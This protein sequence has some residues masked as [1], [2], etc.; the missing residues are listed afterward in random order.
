M[1]SAEVLTIEPVAPYSVRGSAKPREGGF[2]EMLDRAAQRITESIEEKDKSDEPSEIAGTG[3]KVAAFDEAETEPAAPPVGGEKSETGEPESGE[4]SDPKEEK[5]NKTAGRTPRKGGARVLQWR[6]TGKRVKTGPV[7]TGPAKTGVNAELKGTADS[8][9]ASSVK[10]GKQKET[11]GRL[12]VKGFAKKGAREAVKSAGT[13]TKSGADN[14]K[15]SASNRIKPGETGVKAAAESLKRVDKRETVSEAREMKAGTDSVK[16][17]RTASRS[18]MGGEKS[19]ALR[20]AARRLSVSPRPEG[21]GKEQSVKTGLRTEPGPVARYEGA[22]RT[23]EPKSHYGIAKYADG[24]FDEIVKQFTLLVGKGGGEA[25]IVLQPESL[26]HLKLNI[27][28]S[29]QEVQTS[30]LVDN[31]AVRDLIVSKLNILEESLLQHGFNLGSCDVGVRDGDGKG[32]AA[33]NGKR[34]GKML[35]VMDEAQDITEA[36][37]QRIPW[38]STVVN[39]TV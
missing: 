4:K 21:E 27:K 1:I 30:I 19:Q 25:R 26:G 38:M 17:K 10:D 28:L 37:G 13:V 24:N 9:R 12:N 34:K 6:L 23:V 11:D 5:V 31:Q 7:K 3:D 14:K 20:A 22:V 29:N 8:L 2:A 15:V 35:P 16:Q 36:P 32:A 33:G 18:G 39:I